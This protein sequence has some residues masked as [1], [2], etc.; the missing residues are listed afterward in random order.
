MTCPASET[1][2]RGATTQK[3]LSTRTMQHAHGVGV[4][5]AQRA[6]HPHT[7]GEWEQQGSSSA[8]SAS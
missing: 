5:T 2:E 6:L 8:S 7:V 3:E 1:P 4:V